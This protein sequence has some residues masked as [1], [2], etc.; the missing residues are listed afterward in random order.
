MSIEKKRLTAQ[1]LSLHDGRQLG[2]SIIGKGT[3]VVYFHGTASSRLEV[4]L[5]KD[6][7]TAGNLQIIGIDRPGYGLSTFH[8]R[9][10]FQDFADDVDYLAKYLGFDQFGILGWSGGGTFALAY[11]ALFPERVNRA[12]VVG[13][14]FLPFDVSTAHNM[15]LARFIMKIPSLGYL[16]MKNMHSD[17]LKT[18][19]D[20]EAF[21]RSRTGKH[22]LNGCSEDDLNFFGDPAWMGLMY[23]SV[24]EAFRQGNLAVKTVV[25]EHQMFMKQW[26]FS[27]SK[28][29]GDRLFIW[30]GAEDK[31]CRVE[32]AYL[33]SKVASCPHVMVFEGK[34]HCV[35]FGNTAEL[36][37]LLKG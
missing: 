12:V 7:A 9:K 1:V 10:N 17:V 19:G 29:P 21:L 26:G 6:L 18:N 32:N 31:T 20:I 34:G 14:P 35:M 15:P 5:L 3:P 8:E 30:H 23:Q 27:F 37:S 2:Y 16:A 28:V 13:A 4:L 22:M 33:L 24:A 25:Q 36:A 11:L